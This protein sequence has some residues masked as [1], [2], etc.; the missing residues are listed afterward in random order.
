MGFRELLKFNDA[1]LAKQVWRLATNQDTLFYR[2]FKAKIFPHSSIFEAK[3]NMG[4]FAWKSILK[5]RDTIKM[6]L[7]GRV[8]NGRSINVFKDQ[9]LPCVGSGRVLSPPLNHDPDLKVADLI[10]HE[11]H[12]WNSD[13]VNDIFL[14]FEAKV[15]L[16]FPLSLVDTLGR[17]FW[18][19]TKSGDYSVKS[20]DK[21]LREN[22]DFG[23][24]G[25][26]DH[27]GNREVWKQL[28]KLHVPNCIPSLLWRACC[29]FLP[30]KVNL[31]RR[32]IL[33][34]ATCPNCNLEPETITHALWLCQMLDSLWL[35]QFAKLKEATSPLT[36]FIELLH[37]AFK[38]PSCIE[39]FA[40]TV[41]LI[42]MRRNR[43]AFG[44]VGSSLEKIPDQ[45]RA[46]VQ[47]F[48]LLRLVH[49]K[50]PRTACSIRWK[51]PPPGMV[52]VNF[53]GAI[54]S[55]QSLAGLGMVVRDQARLV[56][57]PFHKR[58]PCLPQKGQWK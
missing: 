25:A 12:C 54:F 6:G 18:T 3:N 55:I 30:S 26:S 22:D 47:E 52:K 46:L 48:N 51:P 16:A 43:A 5:G 4:S 34:V 41:S 56:W 28:W 39:V 2:F 1:L 50:I 15:I 35:P 32:K 17:L 45:A 53:N 42:W 29:D 37:L 8:G 11:L 9:W 36:S 57:L 14:P 33:Q 10:D 44:D 38:D 19:K 7:K 13:L 49:P 24:P 58:F 31:V 20:G 27:T 23:V 21:L 40:N